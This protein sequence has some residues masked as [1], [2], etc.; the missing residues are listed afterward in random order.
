MSK[1]KL[2]KAPW[3]QLCLIALLVAAA[4]GLW[5]GQF[6]STPQSS[7]QHLAI[8]RPTVRDFSLTNTEGQTVSLLTYRGKWLLMFFGFTMCPE[9]CPLAMQTVSA[10]LEDMGEVG[11]SI[12]PVFVT[13]DPERDTPAVLRDYLANFSDNIVGLSGSADET[14]GIAKLYGVYYRK[15]PLGNDYTMDHSTALYLVAPDGAYMRPFRADLDASELAADIA[16]EI[17]AWKK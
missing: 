9:A 7:E 3:L 11:K 13:I 12:Q 2:T 5:L 14:A 10:T 4:S 17:Q 16:T 6:M 8:D 15:R 1:S